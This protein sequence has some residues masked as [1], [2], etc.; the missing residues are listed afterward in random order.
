MHEDDSVSP[1]KLLLT[2]P[3]ALV[4]AA[5]LLGGCGGGMSKA[6]Y[7]RE[8]SAVGRDVDKAMREIDGS[9]VQQARQVRKEL[10]RGVDRLRDMD[11]PEE[12]ADAHEDLIHGLE[13]MVELMEKYEDSAAEAPGDQ[14]RAIEMLEELGREDSPLASIESARQQYDDAGYRVFD[15]PP[16]GRDPS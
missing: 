16:K 11:P 15:E 2:T 7:E 3:L 5:L 10:S 4:S 6:E 8:M 12:V 13:G 9:G 14:K 1:F